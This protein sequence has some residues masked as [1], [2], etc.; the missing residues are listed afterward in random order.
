MQENAVFLCL[1]GVTNLYIIYYCRAAS[2]TELCI[3]QGIL[4]PADAVLAAD[5]GV[6]GIIV[7]N[8]GGRQLDFAPATMDVLPLIVQA[9]QGRT[10]PILVDGGV[11]RGTDIVKAGIPLET[12]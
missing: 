9:L 5:A 12:L 3:V 1:T 7:S 6:D 8:Q 11:R 2:M 10:I 4:S